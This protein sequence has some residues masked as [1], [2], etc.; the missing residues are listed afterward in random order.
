MRDEQTELL[1]VGAGP[2]GLLTAIV[3][4]EAGLSVKIIDQEARTT[5]R[6]Y[7]CALH[8]RT[9]KLLDG[10]GLAAPIIEQGRRIETVG[11]YDHESRR[12]EVKLSDAGGAFPFLLIL[13]QSAVEHVLEQRLQKAGVTVNWNH[14]FDRCQEQGAAVTATV[15]ELGGTATGYIVP[16]WETVV[17]KRIPVNAQFVVGADGHASLVRQRLGIENTRVSGPEFFAA[18]EFESDAPSEPEVRVVL[19]ET[20]TNVLWPLAGNKSRWTFQL[21]KSDGL[22]ELPGKE[23]RPTRFAQPK[24]DEEI[25]QYVEQIARQ[26]APW[27]SAKLRS[28][29]WCTDVVFEHRM[30][31][32]FGRNRCWLVGDAA[33]QTGPAGVQSM[34]VGLSEAA[35]LVG[36]LRKILRE[37]APFEGLE[38]Y[39]RERQE[40]WQQLLGL[41]GGLKAGPKT[42]S[43]VS[44]RHARILPC[45]PG[46]G[47]DLT[48]LAGQLGLGF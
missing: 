4:A 7:A 14:R 12:A 2:V 36:I 17:V 19:D 6:S 10:L 37:R 47:A 30:A 44:Q 21:L 28:L 1:V 31:K 15:E 35:Q 18:Y 23:R 9:L 38:T 24:V 41:A 43:W 22:S 42:N 20:T 25:R 5:A 27:F 11:F 8:P 45:L 48:R 46:S 29:T 26:R 40:E 13:P 33:H 32:Q 16:H 39:N 34:N 3:A